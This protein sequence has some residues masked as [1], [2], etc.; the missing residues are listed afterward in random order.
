MHPLIRLPLY[1]NS[2]CLV[3]T[4]QYKSFQAAMR[5]W[6]L[7]KVLPNRCHT[8]TWNA[9]WEFVK[10][11]CETYQKDNRQLV[12][13]TFF[14]FWH[15][16]LITIWQSTPGQNRNCEC[17]STQSLNTNLSYLFFISVR[18]LNILSTKSSKHSN[19]H[20]LAMQPI[21]QTVLI[22]F[23]YLKSIFNPFSKK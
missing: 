19:V 16:A 21:L 22:I 2:N 6:P 15:C 5:K 18:S 17:D 3:L 23:L 8:H 1:S 20:P 11:K 7:P 13:V 9:K 10:T 12:Q 14:A 4:N